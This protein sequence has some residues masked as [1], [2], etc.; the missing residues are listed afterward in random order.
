MANINTEL[1]V[2]AS[3]VY[4]REMRGSIHDAIQKVNDQLDNKTIRSMIFDEYNALPSAQKM[5]GA[6]YFTIDTKQ[7][8]MDGIEY[9]QDN[10]VTGMKEGYYLYFN[11]ASAPLENL[12]ISVKP[13]QNTNG[14]GQAWG[15]GKGKNKLEI[16]AESETIDGISFTV[17]N[18]QKIVVT[19]TSTDRIEYNLGTFS[20]TGSQRP[21]YLNGCPSG[22]SSEKY[23]L[24]IRGYYDYGNDPN[25]VEC[26]L[27]PET[28]YTAKIIISSGVTID[29]AIFMP[30]VREKGDSSFTPYKNECPIVKRSSVKYYSLGKNF[31]DKDSVP[32]FN[33]YI[34][35]ERG[36]KIA[37]TGEGYYYRVPI[38]PSVTY[39]LSGDFISDDRVMY[40]YTFDEIENIKRVY[41]PLTYSDLPYTFTAG[42]N[43]RYFGFSYQD[44]QLNLDKVQLEIGTMATSYAEYKNHTYILPIG[45]QTWGGTWHVEDG[46]MDEEWAE[47]ASYA[48]ENLPSE[49][50]SSLNTYSSGSTPS[51]GAQ[52]VYKTGNTNKVTTGVISVSTIKGL[53]T[54][55]TDNNELIILTYVN[56]AWQDIVHYKELSAEEYNSLSEEDQHSGTIFFLNDVGHIYLNG[57]AYGAGGGGG[58]H[59][60]GP[61]VIANRDRSVSTITVEDT[62]E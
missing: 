27:T 46:N 58:G 45:R 13:Y 48:G 52:V 42:P 21:W 9:T 37:K 26:D 6:V 12:D 55:F 54:M 49:W 36:E 44:G 18:D 56:E 53:N 61:M 19:G 4:G 43:A 47:I 28:T 30:M 34:I 16:T 32:H 33:N 17:T 59:S 50:Y 24:N 2:I 5:N 35:N 7:I 11:A 3:S 23:R 25:G 38:A 1:N 41:G 57:V 51:L 15:G 29:H 14:Y 31:F 60:F 8:F 22:G 62:S 20:Y 39:T 40:V 10:S